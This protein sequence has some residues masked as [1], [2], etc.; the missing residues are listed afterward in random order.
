AM[1]HGRDYH[2][3]VRHRHRMHAIHHSGIEQ[4]YGI[5]NSVWDHVFGTHYPWRK[6]RA[7]YAN[8][9]K[10]RFA[11]LMLAG[12]VGCSGARPRHNP[13][14]IETTVSQIVR[15]RRYWSGRGPEARA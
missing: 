9:A 8:S 13:R 2:A 7:E 14:D 11:T 5:T 10:M 6:F 3:F 4:N 12:N 15:Y 1:H